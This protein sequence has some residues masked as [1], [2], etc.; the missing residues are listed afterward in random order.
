MS[1]EELPRD[2][3]DRSNVT[4][5]PEIARDFA[6]RR[7]RT[8]AA[9][10]RQTSN[11]RLQNSKAARAA[12]RK[13]PNPQSVARDSRSGLCPRDA[14]SVAEPRIVLEHHRPSSSAATSHC[15]VAPPSLGH[16]TGSALPSLI[17]K[18]RKSRRPHIARLVVCPRNAS[19]RLTTPLARGCLTFRATC[20]SN[21]NKTSDRRW[22]ITV[23]ITASY[24]RAGW[25]S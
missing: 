8:Q 11:P 7:N 1:C 4:V 17:P 23:A 16:W 19:Q 13:T 25:N 21:R 18:S 5:V 2:G 24:G 22:P 20:R 14:G 12:W 15:S 6:R 10:R 3:H 9:R